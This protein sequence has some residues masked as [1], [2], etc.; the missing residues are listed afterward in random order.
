MVRP[1]CRAL[2]VSH[3]AGVHEGRGHHPPAQPRPLTATAV[4]AT[5]PSCPAGASAAALDRKQQRLRPEPSDG[6]PKEEG[7]ATGQESSR[8]RSPG[9]EKVA[10]ARST[11]E[12]VVWARKHEGEETVLVGSLGEEATRARETEEK[13]QRTRNG[14]TRKGA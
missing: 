13:M 12:R 10:W 11:G 9:E 8:A 3:L 7:R 2:G 6:G 5:A 1:S 4:T 14:T